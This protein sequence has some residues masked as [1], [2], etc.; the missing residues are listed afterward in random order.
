LPAGRQLETTSV[1]LGYCSLACW[2]AT[3]N[4]FGHWDIVRLPTGRQLETTSVTLGYCSL[5]YWKATGNFFGHTRI[6][7]GWSIGLYKLPALK[8]PNVTQ[9]YGNPTFVYS[10]STIALIT[11]KVNTI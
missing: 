2:K 10:I 5:A 9:T 6:F 8:Y 3:G 7:G 1:T 11:L 4:Y